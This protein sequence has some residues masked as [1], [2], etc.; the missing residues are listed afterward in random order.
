MGIIKT[1]LEIAQEK[2][3]TVKSDKSSIDQFN[4]KQ[5]G[6]KLA[7]SFLSGDADI[8]EELK[9][10]PADTVKSFRR[11]IFDVLVAQLILPG[12]KEDEKRLEKLG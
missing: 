2:T 9:K 3:E 12:S 5:N 1:A 6:K 11:G 8:E 4:A 7:N 10:A